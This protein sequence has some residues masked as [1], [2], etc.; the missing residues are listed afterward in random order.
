MEKTVKDK[1]LLDG[2][3]GYV[4]YIMLGVVLAIL[5]RTFCF[6]IG[7]VPSGSMEPTIA[8]GDRIF[9]NRLINK[10][11]IQRGEIIIFHPT[12]DPSKIFVKRLIGVGG[13]TVRID[14]GVVYVNGIQLVEPYVKNKDLLSMEEL[15][16]PKDEF[17]F[18]GDNRANSD[19][20]RYWEVKTVKKS[21]IVG[22]LAF[23]ITEVLGH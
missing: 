13:D 1:R 14:N 5:L 4:V 9:I 8:I 18:L 2:P 17:F 15:T 10:S 22:S 16:V 11:S 23:N 19:D 21:A 7:K 3:L 20:A 6:T 12:I